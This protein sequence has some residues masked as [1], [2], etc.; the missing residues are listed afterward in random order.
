MAATSEA[1]GEPLPRGGELM[2]DWRGHAGSMGAALLVLILASVNFLLNLG[3]PRA[4][5]WDESYYLTATE[6]YS[7]GI[8]QFASHPPLGLMLIA[9]GDAVLHPNDHL[10]TH[11]LGRVKSVSGE[12]LPAGFS[13]AG[14]RLAS[15]LFAVLAALAFYGLM[16]CLTESV[17][18][19][20]A[21]SNLF[22][23]ENAFI[24]QFRAAHLDAFQVAFAVLALWCFTAAVKRGSG[25]S[26]PHELGLGAACGLAM[27]VKLNGGVLLALCVLLVA[28]RVI[29][30]GDARPRRQALVPSAL[31]LAVMGAGTLSVVL[32]VFTTHVLISGRAMDRQTAAGRAD[33]AFLSEDY[34]E[35]LQGKRPLSP[36][37]LLSAGS[38]YR[39]FMLND[40]THIALR[41]PNASSPL[42][43]PLEQGTINYRWDSDGVRTAYVQLVGNLASW[44]LALLA[45][46]AA[47]ALLLLQWLRPVRSSDPTRRAL[48]T[49]LFIQYVIFLAVHAYLGTQRVMY[50]YHYFIGLLICFTLLPLTLR[51]LE[52]RF[53]GVRQREPAVLGA[54]TLV[55]L[56]SFIFYSPLSFHRPLA[57]SQCEARNML[58][59]VVDCR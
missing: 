25:R 50:L 46:L 21:F 19:A 32:A 34:A 39:K 15:G 51:E 27:M 49:L 20:L 23:F 18:P 13:F 54:V 43:W 16:L 24:T 35:Y 45:L 33:T 5:I 31:A 53:P 4:P 8:A 52:D 22:I 6:R 48:M 9:A 42:G 55:V 38:D 17:L 29:G 36:S 44:C 10:D 7:E 58:Q 41:D 11:D 12:S 1:L 57:H 2:I 47:P 56:G 28:W 26:L 59:H 14:V 37:V 40:F 3:E 30:A